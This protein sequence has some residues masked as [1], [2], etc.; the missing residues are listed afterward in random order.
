[1]EVAAMSDCAG[2]L[3]QTKIIALQFSYF[4][5]FFFIIPVLC[6][7]RPSCPFDLPVRGQKLVLTWPL[8]NHL[9]V[10]TSN[11][12]REEWVPCVLLV[13]LAMLH[14]AYALTL[15]AIRTALSRLCTPKL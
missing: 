13:T 11:A 8:L 14:K 15:V 5:I 10:L 9:L 12:W 2:T 1:M 3:V 4:L 6:K 7:R